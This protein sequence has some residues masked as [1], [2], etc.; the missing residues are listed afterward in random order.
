MT[1]L[2]KV[3]GSQNEFFILDQTELTRPMSNNEL[4]T[5]TKKITDK[6]TGLLGGADGVLVV[7]TPT[8]PEDLAKMRVINKDGS[9]ASMCGNG[10]R[11]V[12]RYVYEKYHKD[13]FFVDTMNANLQVQKRDNFTEKVPA[14][15][16]EISPVS[17]DPHNVGF[18][19]LGRQR[20]ID[21]YLPE[22]YPSLRFTSV[23]V[24]NPH[25]ISFV[26]KETIEGTALGEI[27]QRLNDTNPYFYNGVNV[28][29]AQIIEKNKIFVRTF[30][31]GVG[32]TN[33]CGTGMS[34]TSLALCLTHP[35]VA[36]FEE[37]LTVY[38]PGGLVKTIVHWQDNHYHI[39]LIGNATFTHELELS[40][41]DLHHQN[42]DNISVQETGEQ[43]AY[44]EFVASLPHFNNLT[45]Y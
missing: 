18:D 17:F 22:I 16:F 19:K 40:E 28:N 21:D 7:D 1:Q 44:E 42:F 43:A 25:L 35:D 2:F 36:K 29:F 5:F 34:A 13:N 6:K 4:V 37:E 9:E 41:D 39:D 31:R 23:A 3:H 32:Y 10:L 15:A 14:F 12:A 26:D 24:P 33:A 20:I 27:G 45:V 30:E 11:T 38:N 8:R